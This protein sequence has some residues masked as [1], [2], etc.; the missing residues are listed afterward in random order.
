[1]RFG[2]VGAGMAGLACAEGLADAG[3][4]VVLWDKGRAPGGRMATRRVPTSVG[5]AQFDFGAQYFTI[6]DPAF[7][8]RVD[9]WT[10]AGLVAAW[11]SAG[12]D[13]HIG[14]PAMNAPLREM[15]AA[16]R[17]Y[18]SI[19]ITRIDRLA[20]GWR[21]HTDDGAADA[22]GSVVDGVVIALP[23]EQAAALLAVVAPELA[24]RATATRSLPCWS[25]MLAFTAPVPVSLNHLRGEGIIGVASRNNSKTGRTGPESWVVHASP[26]W[27]TRH[28]EAEPEWITQTLAAALAEMLGT[29]LPP[30]LTASSHRWRFARSGSDGTG[31][32][33]DAARRLGVCGDWLIGPRVEAAWISGT[34]LAGRIAE[35]VP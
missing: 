11:P 26:E 9:Q 23:A 20:S 16:R 5:E 19:R 14:V 21:L 8:R 6:R 17:V 13:A 10:A 22:A 18:W 3:H 25:A 31:S 4:D 28:L 33:W 27:S 29:E 32:M 30:L 1:M 35:S 2:I 12:A 15:A 24:A 7:R 34:G